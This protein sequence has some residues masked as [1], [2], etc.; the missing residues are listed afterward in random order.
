MASMVADSFSD[1]T[2]M[3]Q[4]NPRPIGKGYYGVV[5][6][7]MH[8]ETMEWYAIKSIRKS[9]V[10]IETLRREVDAL[11]E[12]DHPNI[13]KLVDVHEDAIYLHLI[14]ELC[15]GGELFDRIITKTNFSEK[16]AAKLI[17]SILNAIRYCHAKNIAHRD[18]KPENF[19]FMSNEEDS[20]IK[21]IDFGLSKNCNSA[22]HGVMRTRLGTP[23]YIAPEILGEHGY[24]KSCDISSIGVLAY[25]LLSGIPPFYG[26]NDGQIFQS[27]KSGYFTFNAPEWDNVSLAAKDFIC[28]LLRMNPS[29][30]L[31]ASDALAHPWIA[32]ITGT[33]TA[34][35]RSSCS[36]HH[37]LFSV[38]QISTPE[39]IHT[40]YQS[41][42]STI[43]SALVSNILSSFA[44]IR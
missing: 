16:E 28:C 33:R 39:T 2:V 31:S 10:H 5:R 9:K 18:V 35:R 24:T 25:I 44:L 41:S 36:A 7:C 8:R 43:G 30:R 32:G 29:E 13:I 37:A 1:V 38:A 20:P 4:I 23:Y 27:V 19:M 12:L 11:K 21:L 40:S 42:W 14:T 3:Y 15:E 22:N 34:R 17:R 6:K 26:D